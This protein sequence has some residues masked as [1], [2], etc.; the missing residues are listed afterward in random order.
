VSTISPT[1]VP[2]TAWLFAWAYFACS[3]FASSHF[4]QF[5]PLSP[6]STTQTIPERGWVRGYSL[7]PVL[8]LHDTVEDEFKYTQVCGRQ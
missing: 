6:I 1:Q 4:V 7:L 5:C 8:L 2:F 3:H